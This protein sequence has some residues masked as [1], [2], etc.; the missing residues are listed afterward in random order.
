MGWKLW[1]DD[2][3]FPP[4]TSWTIARSSEAAICF[5]ARYGMPCSMSLDHDLGGDDTTMGFLKCLY[6]MYPDS[7]PSTWNIHSKN[8]VGAENIQAFLRS[9]ERAVPAKEGVD[10]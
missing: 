9:W 2:E 5:V 10:V 1:L 4:D 3:R 6:T 7:P 8:P